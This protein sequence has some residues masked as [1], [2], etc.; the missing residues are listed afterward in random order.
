MSALYRHIVGRV[1]QPN[2]EGG[3]IAHAEV[4]QDEHEV[5]VDGV[6]PSLSEVHQECLKGLTERRNDQAYDAIQD[7]LATPD[8]R[9][10]QDEKRAVAA[11]KA[12]TLYDEL[13]HVL[14][15]RSRE[16][17]VRQIEWMYGKRMPPGMTK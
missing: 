3:T 14:G 8:A 17:T 9:L 7:F 6:S 12:Q 10:S 11:E 2:A 1:S 4:P 13:H 15:H 16:H 5:L